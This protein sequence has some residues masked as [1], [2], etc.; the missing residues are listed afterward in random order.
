MPQQWHSTCE[1]FAAHS[2]L[3]IML[4]L[5]STLGPLQEGFHSELLALGDACRL[6]GVQQRIGHMLG[7]LPTDQ[8]LLGVLRD[9]LT[10]AHPAEALAPLLAAFASP[11]ERPAQSARL[12]YTLEVGLALALLCTYVYPAG[13]QLL[14]EDKQQMCDR[15][16][17]LLSQSCLLV[18]SSRG[19]PKQS[20][21]HNVYIRDAS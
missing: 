12:L 1:I 2:Q 20:P 13:G 15:V 8:R 21:M 6:P 11:G 4:R 3:C 14:K 17:V 18:Y 19:S 7:M 16:S 10:S 9:A 5:T